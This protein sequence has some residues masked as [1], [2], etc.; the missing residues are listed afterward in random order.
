MAV[1]KTVEPIGF[2]ITL[3]QFMLTLKMPFKVDK[4]TGQG[5]IDIENHIFNY[6]QFLHNSPQILPL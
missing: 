5:L 4:I 6:R 3:P 1:L 2:M